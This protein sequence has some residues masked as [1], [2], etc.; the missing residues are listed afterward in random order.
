VDGDLARVPLADDQIAHRLIGLIDQRV[1]GLLPGGE[2]H[3]PAGLHLDPALA[4][5]QRRPALEHQHLLLLEQVVVRHVGLPARRDLLEAHAHVRAAAVLAELPEPRPE[6]LA[7][8]VLLPR[9]VLHGEGQPDAVL[10]HR[11]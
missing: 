5:P 6:A 4:Q 10:A 8:G 9:H 2:H 1:P 11:A 3:V 7:V